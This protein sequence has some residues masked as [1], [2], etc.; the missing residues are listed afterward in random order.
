[1]ITRILQPFFMFLNGRGSGLSSLNLFDF[2]YS[3]MRQDLDKDD[4]AR[5]HLKWNHNGLQPTTS[6]GNH[7]LAQCSAK[8]AQFMVYASLAS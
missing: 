1:M 4:K 3:E 5:S 2:W 6:I 8:A 7:N